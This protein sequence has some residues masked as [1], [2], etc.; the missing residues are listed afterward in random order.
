MIG[1]LA[2][3]ALAAA[4]AALPAAA[5]GIYRC[6][7]SYSQQ[8]CPGGNELKAPAGPSAREQA[9]ARQE[10]RNEARTADAMERAR[11]KEEAKPVPVYIPPEKHEAASEPGK[12]G[13]L[14]NVKRP[15]SPYFSAVPPAEPKK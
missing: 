14:K 4:S 15:P 13:S 6:G 12:P 8:P 11:L 10:A 7:N 3:F 9:R 2:L 1:R 5:Q